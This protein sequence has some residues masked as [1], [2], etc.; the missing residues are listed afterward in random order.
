MVKMCKCNKKKYG[1]SDG[2][3]EVWVCYNCGSFDGIAKG[4]EEFIDLIM[5]DPNVVLSLI[6]AKALIP[7]RD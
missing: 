3:H 5:A 1:Y 6:K 7:I 4:D 2:T